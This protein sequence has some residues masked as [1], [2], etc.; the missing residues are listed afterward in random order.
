M[1][2]PNPEN[3]KIGLYKNNE[4]TNLINSSKNFKEEKGIKF[5]IN[6]ILT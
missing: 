5:I 3:D 6:F 1:V 4:I 2:F